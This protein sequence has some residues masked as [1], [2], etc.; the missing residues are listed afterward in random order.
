MTGAPVDRVAAE[1]TCRG[2]SVTARELET[3][4]YL[5]AE[6]EVRIQSPICAAARSFS[7]LKGL[8]QWPN[9]QFYQ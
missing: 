2:T 6:L 1:A 3:E 8:T 7:S 9:R 4:D 5:H